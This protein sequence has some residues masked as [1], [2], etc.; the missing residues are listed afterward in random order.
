M[1]ATLALSANALA[2]TILVLTIA[3]GLRFAQMVH[4]DGNADL[5]RQ[6]Q[7][8][9][10]GE[11][12]RVDVNHCS[13]SSQVMILVLAIGGIFAGDFTV[14]AFSLHSKYMEKSAPECS[15]TGLIARI[16]GPQPR[17]IEEEEEGGGSTSNSRWRT[18][19]YSNLSTAVLSVLCCVSALALFA[20]HKTDLTTYGVVTSYPT[21]V[22]QDLGLFPPMRDISKDLS[23][24]LVVSASATKDAAVKWLDTKG[25]R[26][27]TREPRTNPTDPYRTHRIGDSTYVGLRTHGVG[28]NMASFQEYFLTSGDK[29]VILKDHSYKASLLSQTLSQTW[30]SAPDYQFSSLEA[31]VHGTEIAAVCQDVTAQFH[32]QWAYGHVEPSVT[33]S[34]NWKPSTTRLVVF[35]IAGS[36]QD[37]GFKKRIFHWTGETDFKVTPYG[38][39]DADSSMGLK[40]HIVITDTKAS[41]DAFVTVLECGYQGN[42]FETEVK[43][44]TDKIYIGGANSRQRNA[45]PLANSHIRTV[46]KA[47]ARVLEDAPGPLDG[48]LSGVRDVLRKKQLRKDANTA[49]MQAVVQDVLTDLA[50]AYWSLMRQKIETSLGLP[51]L[52]L[53]DQVLEAA[54]ERPGGELRATYTRL[55]GSLWG[56]IMPSLLLLLPII[57]LARVMQAVFIDKIIDF[58][59][60]QTSGATYGQPLLQEDEEDFDYMDVPPPMPPPKDDDEEEPPPPYSQAG[61]SSAS[62][63]VALAV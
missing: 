3:Y 5:V 38:T 21:K 58:R 50:Q 11:C 22:Y 43:I 9:F 4:V 41:E 46:R 63:E 47:I 26:E 1:A 59:A 55:G 53:P 57:S 31:N 15:R 6:T 49:L 20:P 44:S 27:Y 45:R 48:A 19:D 51:G 10:I 24:F 52:K 36:G 13:W 37:H 16:L 35:D 39:T 56:L 28:V 32:I 2:A 18:R 62:E 30:M 42:D 61:E 60:R 12:R 23:E 34:P 54:P 7:C 14:W 33:K 17:R 40:Q 29:S 8:L 25:D